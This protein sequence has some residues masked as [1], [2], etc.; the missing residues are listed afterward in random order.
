MGLARATDSDA[1]DV[2]AAVDIGADSLVNLGTDRCE[3]LRKLGCGDAIDGQ[4]LMV[5]AL[6]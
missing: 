4:P 1:D 6:E 2:P 3:P 5:D